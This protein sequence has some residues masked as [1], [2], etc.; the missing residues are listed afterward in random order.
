M[1]IKDFF[2]LCIRNWAL[3]VLLPISTAVA[4]FFF[5]K[6]QDKEYSSDTV[7][8]TGITSGY[9]INSE[10]SS[11]YFTNNKAFANLLSI[12]NSRETKQEVALVLLAKHLMLKEHDP[13]MLSQKTYYRLQE[14]IDKPLRQQLTGL[15]LEETVEKLRDHF[16]ANNTNVIYQLLNSE[17]PGYS[18]SALSKVNAY[19]IGASDLMKVEYVSND[20]A[21]C[22]LTLEVLGNVF[23]KRHESLMTSQNAS[24][25]SY[26][27]SATEKAAE[28]LRIAEQS[29][30]DFHKSNDIINY[31]EKASNIETN[32]QS[33]LQQQNSLELD[34][35][36]AVS[37]LKAI[38]DNLKNKGSS[39]LQNQEIISLRNRLS[40]IKTEVSDLE[41]LW[42]NRKNAAMEERISSLN[43][44]AE[45]VENQIRVSLQNYLARNQS[46]N[47]V[48]NKDLIDQWIKNTVLVEEMR[49]KLAAMRRQNQMFSKEYEKVAPLGADLRK[50]ERE[51]E[52][53][54]KE[55]FSLL[56]S[57]GQSQLNQQNIE[58]TSKIKIV[59]PAYTPIKP[60][61]SKRP[62]LVLLGAAA[63]FCMVLASLVLMEL[64]FPK[65]KN[66]YLASK[67]TG[68]PVL[69]SMPLLV[70]KN[71]KNSYIISKAEEQLALLLTLKK[72]TEQN[73]NRPFI[74]GVLS[75]LSGE[76]K[77]TVLQSLT[78]NL[79]ALGFE[80]LNMFPA[81]HAKQLKNAYNTLVY[82]PLK[83]INHKVNLPAVVTDT[84][85][86]NGT[87]AIIEFPALL[88][89]PYPIAL[90]Q[91]LDLVLMVV[92]ADREWK[93]SDEKI[94]S[95]LKT[96][97]SKPIEI[98][99]NGV[100]LENMEDLISAKIS[101]FKKR[102]DSQQ[103]RDEAN[104]ESWKDN[105]AFETG[106]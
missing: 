45:A 97:T 13:A 104:D 70:N 22:R 49:G 32:K 60:N 84:D 33:L 41:S 38:E 73:T 75:S 63:T 20:P 71:D 5:T 30:L 83:G 18:L 100:H 69:G 65:L 81:D 42:S 90:I 85:I 54:E 101:P 26:F 79:R 64:V 31:Q 2:L 52:M 39:I 3:L 77:T 16:R 12:I 93:Q 19:Q 91:Q 11:N 50:L 99:L 105:V 43:Q 44:Q 106:S 6:N 82:N 28:R 36:G 34:Y 21:M 4:I 95:R 1:R 17:E 40:K 98:V 15:T 102:T 58:L 76:G 29:L 78:N 96:L 88:E 61:G 14:L 92:R 68:F 56:S 23:I 25:L 8:F 62:L 74:V 57:L 86:S 27:E 46:V 47:G 87:V 59:D 55:Y 66:T 51:V 24:V 94:A 67:H 7:I 9:N 35:A 48:S 10:S 72:Q 80:V 103:L 89:S 53:A 37:V